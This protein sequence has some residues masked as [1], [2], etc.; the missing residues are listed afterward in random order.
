[1][2]AFGAGPGEATGGMAAEPG[3]WAVL[4]FGRSGLMS[5]GVGACASAGAQS[6]ARLSVSEAIASFV[7][8][9]DIS[10]LPPAWPCR[11]P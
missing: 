3:C 1:M 7:L 10:V 5:K 2:V 6:A 9:I 11:Y 8:M 4:C